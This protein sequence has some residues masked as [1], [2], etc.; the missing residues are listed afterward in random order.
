MR[1]LNF[2][3]YKA[4][5]QAVGI[6]DK[7]L[8]CRVVADPSERALYVVSGQKGTRYTTLDSFCSCPHFQMNVIGKGEAFMCKHLLAVHLV[9][10]LGGSCKER[11]VP[12][13]ELAD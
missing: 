2:V 12:D 7:G 10:L 5:Q 6:V 13:S 1:E 9:K 4:L 11:R 8:V 3:H